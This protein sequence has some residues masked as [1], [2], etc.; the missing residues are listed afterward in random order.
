MDN[1]IDFKV[2]KALRQ[3]GIK[4]KVLIQDIIDEGYD[5]CDP[6][7]VQNYYS[8]K[9]FSSMIHTDQVEHNWTDEAIDNL[10][11]DVKIWNSTENT[12]VT[13]EFDPKIFE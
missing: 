12:T 6:I 5:P 3:S 11:R 10:M 1:V 2:Q 4:D 9:Q 8:W 7:E 13:V